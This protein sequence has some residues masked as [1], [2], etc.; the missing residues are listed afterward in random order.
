MSVFDSQQTKGI[1]YVVIVFAS[2]IQSTPKVIPVKATESVV[3][4]ALMPLMGST[5]RV[6]EW[7]IAK[8]CIV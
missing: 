3:M 4:L 2:S 7:P 8:F 6:L 5:A 1:L